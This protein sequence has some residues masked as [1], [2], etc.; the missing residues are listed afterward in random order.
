[1]PRASPRWNVGVGKSTDSGSNDGAGEKTEGDAATH[2]TLQ[3]ATK[4][5]DG[6]VATPAAMD[7]QADGPL[8][9]DPCDGVPRREGGEDQDAEQCHKE[10]VDPEILKF[11]WEREKEILDLLKRQGRDEG[12]PTLVDAERRC[13]AAKAEWDIARGPQRMSRPLGRA[14]AAVFKARARQA[15]AEQAIGDL[16]AEYEA[17]RASF[18][19]ELAE[20]RRNTKLR[21]AE[22][23]ELQRTVGGRGTAQA[24]GGEEEAAVAELARR[25]DG[26]APRLQAL[27]EKLPTGTEEHTSVAETMSAL[28]GVAGAATEAAAHRRSARTQRYNI[29]GDRAEDDVRSEVTEVENNRGWEAHGHNQHYGYHNYHHHYDSYHRQA[30]YAGGGAWSDQ[31]GGWNAGGGWETAQWPATQGGAGATGQLL[32]GRAEISTGNANA[33]ADEGERK[34]AEQ[35]YADQQAGECQL[36]NARGCGGG[37]G[38]PRQT[39]G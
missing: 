22:L 27:L 25:L 20:A 4:R 28:A 3:G 37:G 10:Q 12:D 6:D 9:A 18:Q 26:I 33:W 31:A 8:G 21:E 15:D 32:E 24:Q 34:R 23:V 16:D 29:G 7:L 11:R 38:G 14:E 30:Y 39:G 13:A 35:A 1:M 5:N 36:R 2:A 19:E 17:K